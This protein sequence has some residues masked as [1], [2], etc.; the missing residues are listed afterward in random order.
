MRA[1]CRADAAI[2]PMVILKVMLLLP[3]IADMN[4]EKFFAGYSRI[5][6]SALQRICR[7][8]SNAPATFAAM[9]LLY[10]CGAG[11]F[12]IGKNRS[13]ADPWPEL[14]GNEL[15]MTSDPAQAGPCCRSLLREV[16]FDMYWIGTFRSPQRLRAEPPGFDFCRQPLRNVIDT[17]VHP[18]I[19]IGVCLVRAVLDSGHYV[20]VHGN[21]P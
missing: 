6:E 4:I 20:R 2:V 12:H 9:A 16:A 1:D 3:F 11:E 13:Q 14:T 10:R 21:S 18:C 8:R 15:A 7:A 19:F 5:P 17:V